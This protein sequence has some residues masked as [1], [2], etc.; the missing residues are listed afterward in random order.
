MGHPRAH[1]SALIMKVDKAE[2]FATQGMYFP[3]TDSGV[4]K[5]ASVGGQMPNILHASVRRL[6]L[7]I[8]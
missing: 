7:T 3:Y 1:T 8:D 2:I 4:M 6:T 5:L